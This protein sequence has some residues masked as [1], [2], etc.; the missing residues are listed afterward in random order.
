MQ[1]IDVQIDGTIKLGAPLAHDYA[2]DCTVYSALYM[3]DR[4]ARVKTAFAQEAWDGKTWSDVLTRNRAVASYNTQLAP[5]VVTNRGA[6][7]ERW[8]LK[9]ANATEVDVIGE[10]VGHLGRFPI[11]TD[12]MPQNPHE[13]VPYFKA[14][15]VGFG[16]G[17]VAGNT[18]FIHT[19]AASAA[20]WAVRTVQKGQGAVLDDTFELTCRYN[21]DRLGGDQP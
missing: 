13:G 6:V 10:H 12:V 20:F 2:Q 5:I 16:G 18:L 14:R 9:F 3:G 19:V 8:A 4:F 11:G 17:W 15:A 1:A 7:T 21:V